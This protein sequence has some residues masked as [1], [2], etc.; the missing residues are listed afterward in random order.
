MVRTQIYLT[1][2]E[3]AALR[4]L[5]RKTGRTQSE[6]IRQA[7]DSFLAEENEFDRS[8]LLSQARGLWKDRSDLPDFQALRR[9]WD[10]TGG[11]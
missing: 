11:A 10:R 5:S 1:E 9:E 4:S 6:L 7:I 8:V 2:E 3:Q